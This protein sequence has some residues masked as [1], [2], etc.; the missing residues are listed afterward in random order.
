MGAPM[1]MLRCTT[2]KTPSPKKLRLESNA[3]GYV[4]EGRL[5]SVVGSGQSKEN[6]RSARL[7]HAFRLLARREACNFDPVEALKSKLLGS[8]TPFLK[9]EPAAASTAAGR[10]DA[11]KVA[12]RHV[13]VQFSVAALDQPQASA[14][15]V[16][17]SHLPTI[18]SPPAPVRKVER[19]RQRARLE[20]LHLPSTRAMLLEKHLQAENGRKAAAEAVAVKRGVPTEASCP[21]LARYL[22][23]ER[24][25][26]PVV[27]GGQDKTP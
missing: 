8:G 26:G 9:P 10:L 22:K 25:R 15:P 13:G 6:G 23:T 1:E 18:L 19:P 24:V 16:M 5:T 27:N 3:D 21:I 17:F 11:N 2:M 14:I 20:S 4:V 12:S 7:S